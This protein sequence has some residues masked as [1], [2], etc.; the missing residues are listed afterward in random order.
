MTVNAGL[1][2]EFLAPNYHEIDGLG[3]ALRNPLTDANTTPGSPF[4]NP[5]LHAISP[6]LGFA[7]DVFGDGKTSLRG[8]AARLYDIGQYGTALSQGASGTPVGPV[9][10]GIK[11]AR[12]RLPQVQRIRLVC[13]PL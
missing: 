5:S 8:G 11:S 3:A 1:R 2:Y 9:T 6:R 10:N 12:Q 7:W 13:L 4:V